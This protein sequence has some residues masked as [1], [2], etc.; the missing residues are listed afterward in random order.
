MLE[1]T[2]VGL[3]AAAVIALGVS[4]HVQRCVVIRAGPHSSLIILLH[5]MLRV[6]L[7]LLWLLL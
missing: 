5:L 1:A 7:L 4:S 3:R 2:L 6:E